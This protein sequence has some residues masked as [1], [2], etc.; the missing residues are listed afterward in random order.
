MLSLAEGT[1]AVQ[2]ARQILEDYTKHNKKP[3]QSLGKSF[4]KKQGVFVTL[5]TFPHHEQRG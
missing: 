3:S 4:H 1:K 2:F 5:H